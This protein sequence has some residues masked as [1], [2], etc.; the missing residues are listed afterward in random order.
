MSEEVNP[1]SQDAQPLEGWLNRR[2]LALV[3]TV[4]CL[5][6]LVG[7]FPFQTY[8]MPELH[9]DQLSLS[10][11]IRSS[12][13]GD[14]VGY[15]R[16]AEGIL[17]HGELRELD[18]T[19]ILKHMPALPLII[20]VNFSSFGT[21]QPFMLFQI[22]FLFL[23]L[24]F[25]L[26]RIRGQFPS[27]AVVAVPILIAVHP[28]TI[29]H[30]AGVMSDLLYGSILLW[31]V[32]LL[33][34]RLP[35]YRD[36]LLAGVVLGVA[37]YVRESAFPLMLGT[38]LAYVIKDRRCYLG[39]AIL[40]GCTFL[41]VL[42]P[43]VVRN[44]LVAGK[45]IPLTA[46][47]W[48]MFYYDSFPL[49]TELYRPFGPG[50]QEGGYNYDK[51]FELYEREVQPWDNQQGSRSLDPGSD[52]ANQSPT[53]WSNRFNPWA[54]RPLP[55]SPIKEGLRNYLTRPGEQVTS[56]LLKSV[57]LFNKPP[58]LEQLAYTRLA[59]LLVAVNI[60]FYL[61][62][63]GTILFG[64][65]LAFSSRNPFIYLPY[66]IVAQY[67]QAI[68]FWSEH[69]YLMPFYPLLILISLT[70]FCNRWNRRAES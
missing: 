23:S 50:F 30:S 67:F 19:P 48:D 52:T 11:R 59:G 58:I 29:K 62:H 27:I 60:A 44:Y 66:W 5:F 1:N 10:E 16:L 15:G 17:Q 63:A 37:V 31:V 14:S 32:F 53:R 21:V 56:L 45:L 26:D 6:V 22:L 55:P 47:S 34:K 51:L 24:F 2:R 33:W 35:G 64:V 68:F 12:K 42:S 36:F 13:F 20:A 39:P 7:S 43:W 8:M 49:T 54:N 70:W 38:G 46:K 3:V 41:A 9:N 57:A 40:M 25:L 28:Q 61:V 18:G 4:C 65:V 69:R